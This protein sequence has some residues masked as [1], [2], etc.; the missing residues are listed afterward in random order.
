[1][2]TSPYIVSNWVEGPQF[3]GREKLCQALITSNERCIYLMGMRRVGKTSLL[4]RLATLLSPH[5]L[6][7]D[8]MQG[9]G[10]AAG[11]EILDE[12][13]VVRLIRRE[14]IRLASQSEPLRATREIWDQ[15][16]TSL[17]VWLEEVSWGWES[18]GL[19]ITLLWDEAEML[20]RL[21]NATLMQLRAV[22]QQSRSL[23]L[24][25]CASKGLAALNDRWRGDD[26]SPFLFGFR[27]QPLAGLDEEAATTL[28]SQ[29][30]AVQVS[31]EAI[32]TI[33]ATTGNHPFLLQTL[34]DRLYHDGRLRMPLDQDFLVDPMMA[35]LFRIDIAQLSPSEYAILEALARHGPRSSNDLHEITSLA[36]ECIHSFAQGMAQ[37]GY[38]R[39]ASEQRWQAGNDFLAR[40]LRGYPLTSQLTVTDQAT[41]EVV[42]AELQQI[43]Q[44]Q[45]QK[46]RRTYEFPQQASAAT[47]R[48]RL[49][50]SP[51]ASDALP[52]HA[53]THNRQMRE[54]P[55]PTAAT[56]LDEPLSEREMTVLRLIATGLRNAEI[57]NRLTVSENTVK[58]HIKNIYRKLGVNDR[59]QANNRARELG[60]L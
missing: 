32:A 38:L 56:A 29:R 41:L 37:L 60:L 42:D 13:R 44:G 25:V 51:R 1:M 18:Q 26:V 35:D 52:T 8:L 53:F 19:T 46:W 43:E 5:A 15:P 39:P 58:A 21:P 7:C 59:V 49:G 31:P 50:T 6:Y 48:E 27:T 55:R 40:W 34:C 17:G 2:H 54:T 9:A 22:M 10:Q 47:A 57:A 45:T 24:I 20:R 11:C 30:G 28:I 12:S 16:E 14:L 4:R 3:Y 23:R 36:A 33:R